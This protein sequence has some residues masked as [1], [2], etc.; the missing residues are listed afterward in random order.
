MNNVIYTATPL[1]AFSG[2]IIAVILMLILGLVGLGMAV[3]R[4]R[5]KVV[6][7]VATGVA[8]A[9]VLLASCALAV[10]LFF[11]IQNGDETVVAHL[12]KKR[13]VESNCSN[14]DGTCTSY[15]ME[16]TANSKYYTFG[17]TQAVLDKVQEDQCYQVTYYT[18]RPLLNLQKNQYADLYVSSSTITLIQQAACP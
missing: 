16:M 10:S 15:E 8:G 11:S 3:F 12:D 14:S 5:Q 9:V 2:G 7:R 13:V 17:V 4:R 18:S 6:G 1:W